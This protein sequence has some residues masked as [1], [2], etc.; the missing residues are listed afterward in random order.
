MDPDFIVIFLSGTEI[1]STNFIR[2]SRGKEDITSS[3]FP[4]YSSIVFLLLQYNCW[5][6]QHQWK[7]QYGLKSGHLAGHSCVLRKP[8]NLLSNRLTNNK[9]NTT[10]DYILILK[11]QNS[12][13]TKKNIIINK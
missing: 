2:N 8:T 7:K 3:F 6:N 10:T 9:T 1:A 11:K 13:K 5:F 4:L 12:T